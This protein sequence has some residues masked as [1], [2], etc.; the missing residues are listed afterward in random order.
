MMSGV[1][2][3]KPK[4]KKKKEPHI[5]FHPPM[6][7]PPHTF[8]HSLLLRMEQWVKSSLEQEETRCDSATSHTQ[9]VHWQRLTASS[10][11]LPV[12]I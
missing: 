2:T 4:K 7:S 8:L 3:N 1:Q 12:A 11:E 6:F 9:A 10:C 5:S